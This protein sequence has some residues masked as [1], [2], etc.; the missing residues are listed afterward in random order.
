M[1]ISSDGWKLLILGA[2]VVFP[3]IK[4]AEAVVKGLLNA[5]S[6]LLMLLNDPL[7]QMAIA[8]VLVP[9]VLLVIFFSNHQFSIVS[10]EA[11]TK[12]VFG[13]M[14]LGFLIVL[15]SNLAKP[16]YEQ[17]LTKL[18]S[19]VFLAFAPIFGAILYVF[20]SIFETLRTRDDA[21]GPRGSITK[22]DEECGTIST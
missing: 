9:M 2:I 15:A 3:V 18:R 11:V 16:E 12:I 20:M 1:R 4:F 17:L 6:G 22:G 5:N 8:Q 13:G 19:D 7:F 21:G 10:A 14:T